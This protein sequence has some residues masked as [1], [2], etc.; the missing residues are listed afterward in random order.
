[1]TDSDALDAVKRC[2]A[3]STF[4]RQAGRAEL[5]GFLEGILKECTMQALN[6]GDTDLAAT[7]VEGIGALHEL[8]DKPEPTH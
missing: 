4:L 6:I 2:D 7:C 8:K 1:M 3:T 5:V